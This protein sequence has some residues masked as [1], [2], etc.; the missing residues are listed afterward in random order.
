MSATGRI[1]RVM[2]LYRL[3]RPLP[4][5]EA[6]AVV[7]A[8]DGWVDAGGAATAAAARIAQGGERLV[9]F[10]PDALFDYRAR[11]PVLDVVDGKLT[12]LD[13]PELSL[14]HVRVE[15]RELLVLTGAEPDYRWRELGRDVLDLARQLGVV[16]WVSLGAIPAA[17]PHTRPV[18][19]LATASRPGLLRHGEVQG[20]SGLLR[21]PAA[22]LSALEF[23]VSGASVPA[24]GFFAQVPHYVNVPYP[25]AA[26][27]LLECVG[28]HLELT[29]DPGELARAAASSRERLDAAVA[30]DAG[31]AAYVRRLEAIVDEQGTRAGEDLIAEIE[32]F[33]RQ[34]AE[35]GPPRP[36]EGP[37]GGSP[38]PEG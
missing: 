36:E 33:L 31:S 2:P 24:V 15:R 30:A 38:R 29:V 18:P 13:W 28:R 6:P 1:L 32:R 21:V 34:R 17:V 25:A 4:H 27:A 23:A 12:G 5:L 10:D 22:A 20:P 3:A 26:V 37:G 8:L 11:R 19:V 9:A 7:A 16:E 35:E 14:W